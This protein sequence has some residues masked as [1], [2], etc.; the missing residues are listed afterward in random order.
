LIEGSDDEIQL[1]DSTAVDDDIPPPALI[2]NEAR[3]D[4]AA[5]LTRP[6]VAGGL[7][8]SSSFAAPSKGPNTPFSPDADTQTVVKGDN[9]PISRCGNKKKKS[10][11]ESDADEGATE[12]GGVVRV[13]VNAS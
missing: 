11:V 4:F 6:T 9:P 1:V 10:I 5:A 13:R 2:G 8:T 7:A 12:E 3:S